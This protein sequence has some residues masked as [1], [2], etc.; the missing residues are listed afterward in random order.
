LTGSAFKAGF[1]YIV[2][3]PVAAY[4]TWEGKLIEG[5]GVSPILNVELKPEQLLAGDDPQMQRA[6]EVVR[7]M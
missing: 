3:L 5:K 7:G 4:L 6:L 1:G 2:G